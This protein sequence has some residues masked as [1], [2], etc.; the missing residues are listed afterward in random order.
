[1]DRSPQTEVAEDSYFVTRTVRTVG[2]DGGVLAPATGY[3]V[4]LTTKSLWDFGAGSVDALN[5]PLSSPLT[6]LIT[7][8]A[9]R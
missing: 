3:G 5:H 8:T 6:I 2:S 1:M 4:R 9:G 7:L